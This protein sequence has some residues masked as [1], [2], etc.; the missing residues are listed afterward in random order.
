[1]VIVGASSYFI[2][3][4]A[5]DFI[6]NEIPDRRAQCRT[7][8]YRDPETYGFT[9]YPINVCPPRMIDW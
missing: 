3:A 7:R 2:A 1:V 4:G 8:P 9:D 5:L 6:G